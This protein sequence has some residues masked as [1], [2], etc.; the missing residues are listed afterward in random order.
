VFL[1]DGKQ[2]VLECLC[3][4]LAV[5]SPVYAGQLNM[6]DSSLA[7][8]L[9]RKALAFGACP[10]LVIALRRAMVPAARPGWYLRPGQSG[11]R[12]RAPAHA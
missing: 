7:L 3:C 9:P 11:V 1:P 2:V 4:A 12:H 8:S 6:H 10:G 5:I